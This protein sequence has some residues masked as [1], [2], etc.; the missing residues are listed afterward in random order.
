MRLSR[1]P[2]ARFGLAQPLIALSCCLA[3]LALFLSASSPVSAKE[4]TLPIKIGVL[5]DMSGPNADLSGPGTVEA[6]RMAVAD[7]GGM[8]LGRP[9]SIEVRDH[10]NSTDLGLAIAREWYDNGV[11]V[12]LDIGLSSIALGVQHLA[13]QEK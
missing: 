13:R 12:I 3:L 10:Q 5:S 2:V 6:V 8:V 7:Y 4:Q 9:V 11:N 1:Y